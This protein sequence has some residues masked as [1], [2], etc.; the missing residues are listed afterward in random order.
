[1]KK[2]FFVLLVMLSAYFIVPFDIIFASNNTLNPG[3]GTYLLQEATGADNSPITVYYYRPDGWNAGDPMVVVFHGSNRNAEEYCR[4][5]K[6]YAEEN[7]LLVICPEFTKQKYPGARYYS[8]GNVMDRFDGSGRI[9][10]KDLWVFSS[11]NRII[12]D[13]K[14]RVDSKNSKVIVFGHSAGGQFL[15]RY[16]F[17]AETTVADLIIPANAGWYTMPDFSV[18]FPYGIKDAPVTESMLAV[19]FAKPVV[20]LLGE[21]DVK[22]TN[23]L[24]ITARADK[25]GVNRLER[26]KNFFATSQKMAEKLGVPF[27]WRLATVPRVG[28]NGKKMAE[29]AISYIKEVCRNG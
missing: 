17:F 1:M 20:V 6:G 14:E 23:N 7:N 2:Q 18:R 27:R 9:Q 12:R 16:I 19:A 25:Q 8:T 11:V 29:G 21:A 5:W 22:R 15:Q 26:G 10:P 3:N 24:R 4:N 13:A 28:H